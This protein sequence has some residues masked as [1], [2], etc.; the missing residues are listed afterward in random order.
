MGKYKVRR[1]NQKSERFGEVQNSFDPITRIKSY[2]FLRNG[3]V[4]ATNDFLSVFLTSA[5]CRLVARLE[6]TDVFAGFS[7]TG[8]SFSDFRRE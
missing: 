5:V 8:L 7:A 1:N 3:S 4:L 6:V 2:G